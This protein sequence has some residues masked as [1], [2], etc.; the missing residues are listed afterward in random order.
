MANDYSSSDELSDRQSSGAERSHAGGAHR[1]GAGATS[2]S[3]EPIR[4]WQERREAE[5]AER[6]E[7]EAAATQRLQ[8]EAIKH[9]DDFYEVYSKKKQQQVEQAR[10]EAEEFLQ[11]RDTFFDQDNTVWDR[12]LQLIN[13]EDADVL[14]DRDRS[15]FKDILLRLKGQE[16]VPGA[17]RG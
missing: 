16:H 1:T 10:R 13:T 12:V 5:I 6:D 17:A 7:S 4:K 2:D 11:Q 15:K 8:A 3:S 9:I 14:G